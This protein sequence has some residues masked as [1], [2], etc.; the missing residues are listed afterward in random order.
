MGERHLPYV[1]TNV[2]VL[3]EAFDRW[4]TFDPKLTTDTDLWARFIA[5]GLPVAAIR[6]PL[7]IRRTHGG[8]L[9]SKYASNYDELMTAVSLAAPDEPTRKRLREDMCFEVAGYLIKSAQPAAARKFMLEKLGDAARR[10]RLYRLTFVPPAL[11]RL[12][13]TL[14]EAWLRARYAPALASREVREVTALIK[15]LLA[16]EGPET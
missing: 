8:Q 5:G 3:R 10:S 12:A 2:T 16:A 4:G 15:P 9:S 11:L 7:S 14:R 13:R 1:T 6:E